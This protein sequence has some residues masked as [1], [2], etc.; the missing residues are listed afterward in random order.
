ME[1]PCRNHDPHIQQNRIAV[2]APKAQSYTQKTTAKVP[3]PETLVLSESLLGQ[4]SYSGPQPLLYG[5]RLLNIFGPFEHFFLYTK[6]LE[7]LRVLDGS[8]FPGLYR[9]LRSWLGIA[10]TWYVFDA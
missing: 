10:R 8:G 6:P 5:L 4:D 3:K 7:T 2:P 1:G 9:A